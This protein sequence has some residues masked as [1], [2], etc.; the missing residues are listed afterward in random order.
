MHRPGDNARRGLSRLERI[1]VDAAG[2]GLGALLAAIA[3]ARGGKAVHP[4]GVVHRA[5]LV[6][7][8]GP[9]APQG[10]DMLRTRAEHDEHRRRTEA[11]G[12]P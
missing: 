10:S 3:A 8:G 5:R 4:N 1:G 12:P 11:G 2:Y 6:V 9:D 7:D